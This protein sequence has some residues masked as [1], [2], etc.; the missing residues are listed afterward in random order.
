MQGWIR[1]CRQF[2]VI[3]L[4]KLLWFKESNMYCS[5]WDCG[6]FQ[7][8]KTKAIKAWNFAMALSSETSYAIQRFRKYSCII[9][10]RLWHPMG[11]LD[12]CKLPSKFIQWDG[13]N[14]LQLSINYMRIILNAINVVILVTFVMQEG[15]KYFFFLDSTSRFMHTSQ[16]HLL[17][18]DI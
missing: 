10:I 13:R 18:M 4:E 14:L 11:T 17:L 7:T 15:V 2:Y 8:W 16:G 12:S 9:H 3:D 5:Y 6:V 1:N